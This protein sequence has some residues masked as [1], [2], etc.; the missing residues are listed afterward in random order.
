MASYKA[1][2]PTGKAIVGTLEKMYGTAGVDSLV[3]DSNGKLTPEYGGCA[4]VDWNSQTQVL[5]LYGKTI[6]VD[7]T[8]Q[9]WT[10][11]DLT[12]TPIRDEKK[13]PSPRRVTNSPQEGV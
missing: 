12:L 6:Y 11:D 2:T 8:G 5:D 3:F 4:E 10:E 13:D 1:T 9:H 7:E